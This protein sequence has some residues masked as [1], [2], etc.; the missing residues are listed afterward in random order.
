MQTLPYIFFLAVHLGAELEERGGGKQ[1]QGSHTSKRLSDLRYLRKNRYWRQRGPE[2][3]LGHA[4]A[5]WH[6]PHRAGRR[7][8]TSLIGRAGAPAPAS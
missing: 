6:Q 2:H 4:R 7:A 1:A 5:R 3:L 8:G